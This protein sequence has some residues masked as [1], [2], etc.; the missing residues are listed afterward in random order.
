VFAHQAVERFRKLDGIEIGALYVFDQRELERVFGGHVA[1]HDQHFAQARA[2]RRSPAPFTR[3][4]LEFRLAAPPHDDRLEHAVLFDR[5]REFVELL[6]VEVLTRL[7]ALRHD[8][9]ERARKHVA[10]AVRG[11][12][13]PLRA[14]HR[15]AHRK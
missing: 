12:R 3:D 15:S 4:D 13:R 1:H 7:S 2:L 10:L 11:R 8:V 14:R 5:L 9:L 6:R